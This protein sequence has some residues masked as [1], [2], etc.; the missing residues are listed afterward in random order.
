MIKFIVQN[1]WRR[2]ER[3]FLSLVGVII[4]SAGLTYLVGLSNQSKGTIEKNLQ[5][6][7][8]AS[9]DIVV[10]PEGSRSIT[11]NKNL[12]EPNYMSG[13]S[14]GISMEQY[15]TIKGIEGVEVAAPIAML[16][17]SNY[18]VSFGNATNLLEPGIYRRKMTRK[19]N[20][21]LTTKEEDSYYYFTYPNNVW[22]YYGKDG[23]YGTG[24]PVIDYTVGSIVL[25]AAIDPEQENK[26]IGLENAIVPKGSSRYFNETDH[27]KKIDQLDT[28]L[29][30][31]PI[32]VNSQNF[33]DTTTSISFERVNIPFS[34]ENAN[35]IMEEIR[36]KGGGDYLDTLETTVVEQKDWTQDEIFQQFVSDTTGVD[37][38]TGKQ[39]VGTS[40]AARPIDGIGIGFKPNPI[41]YEEMT[42]PFSERWPYTYQI[43]PVNNGE[44]TVGRYRNIQTYRQPNVI[45]EEFIDLPRLIP[46]FIGFY[47]ASKLKLSMD[48]TTELPME[49]YRPASAKFVMD[50]KGNPI[51]P[52][53]DVKP[54]D[55][56]VDFLTNP[57]GMLTTLDAAENILGEKPIS[58][59]R[60]KVANVS[61]ANED[62]QQILQRVAKEIEEKTGLITDIT[63]G[64]SPQL[65]LT[66]VPGINGE[67]PI[68]WIEQPWVN[69][70]SA[71]SIL[72][73]ANLGFIALMISV[74]VVAIT[75]V[76]SASI[77]NVLARRKEFAV[78]LAIGW[79]PS[80]L[81]RMLFMEGALIGLFAT[82]ISWFILG[83]ISVTSQEAV[84]PVRFL[85]TGIFALT[86]YIIG[87]FLPMNIVRKIS[88]YEAMREGEITVNGKRILRA[89]SI[90]AIAAN[91]FLTKWKRSFLS[92]LAIAL[93]STL[94]AVFIY[95][96]VR[97]HGVMFTSL[98]GEYV[99]FEV[100]TF[101]Y[102]AI[103]IALLI[104]LL[105]TAEINWQNISE[106]Q[107]EIGI[108]QAIGWRRNSIRKLI[109][110]EGF[111]TGIA[112]MIF[113]VIVATGTVFILY[114]ELTLFGAT[115]ILLSSLVP[116][117]TGLVGTLIPAER[118][119]RLTPMNG[120][121]GVQKTSV[122]KEKLIRRG[123]VVAM[124][125]F[126]TAF[127]IV[128]VQVIIKIAD[129]ENSK[130]A[131][132]Y[133]PTEGGTT[134]PV[135]PKPS[136]SPSIDDNTNEVDEKKPDYLS[137]SKSEFDF[138]FSSRITSNETPEYEF[139]YY[140]AK[141]VGDSP[142]AIEFTFE[143]RDKI[144]YS[145]KPKLHFYIKQ[146]DKKYRPKSV[147]VLEVVGM[148]E[149]HYLMSED[150]GKIRAV[151]TFEGVDP[152]KEF[153][154]VYDN[155]FQTNRGYAIRFDNPSEPT[156]IDNSS[157]G[158][159]TQADYVNPSLSDYNFEISSRITSD[160][161]DDDDYPKEYFYF[162]AKKASDHPLT[163]EFTFE[164][165]EDGINYY[166]KP[167]IHFYVEQDDK[168]YR[169]KPKSVKILDVV[170]M[171]EDNYLK[172]GEGRIR[173]QITFEGVD[174][175][176]QFY[177]VY[178]NA[179]QTGRGFAIRF[180]N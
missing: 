170:G 46:R 83:I 165:R 59:I 61:L 151:L 71:I 132:N 35:E 34:R 131:V 146:K 118:A 100:G 109:L 7:W 87:A 94:L 169:P 105:T 137:M 43:V 44:D 13:L 60:I 11:E 79:R 96:T 126:V 167:N 14:G 41:Q 139:I 25:L 27:Y 90:Y 30:D 73:E 55:D 10:R 93:P 103:A 17:Y 114:G 112:A 88:P 136:E 157:E 37:W 164:A 66:Y 178:N 74:V 50:A 40:Q 15:E 138:E 149:T 174:P 67:E 123:M 53:V 119:S 78:L 86:V 177:F 65:A 117:L 69:I 142:L 143:T 176:K 115:L 16:G 141:K 85:L 5:E 92:V 42:S 28:V 179:R 8:T 99:A 95:I 110:A 172:Y 81:N 45:A 150:G 140:E 64:S 89:N 111:Y 32:I 127:G 158:E 23:S 121:R 54:T 159:N 134:T 108:L 48:P 161:L 91:H 12:L 116:I 2:K 49:T 22:D 82:T 19:I 26:L 148:S 63:L 180:D 154:F 9:Y 3:L 120:I 144:S 70:G 133:T 163:I 51:S 72:K 113:V 162:E 84:T 21:G 98:L 62:S 125:V 4:I 106:R 168:L 97:M 128:M 20:N 152:S 18:M 6:R 173:A 77:V 58:T 130:V 29:H 171:T 102:V 156:I 160:D 33:I 57:P 38:E 175:T 135:S 122:K 68:G 36:E 147:E 31:L 104:A 75:Y 153:Y 129:T 1:W 166:M 76:W 101:H 24:S 56:P 80:Q 145:M 47:D 107:Q 124:A 39:V 52:A 155:Y